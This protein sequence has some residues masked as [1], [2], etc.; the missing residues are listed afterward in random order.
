M[1]PLAFTSHFWYKFYASLLAAQYFYT[2]HSNTADFNA[3]VTEPVRGK[4]GQTSAQLSS[5]ITV[6]M[7]N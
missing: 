5:H 2:V 6:I 3:N 4:L 7:S 1:Y